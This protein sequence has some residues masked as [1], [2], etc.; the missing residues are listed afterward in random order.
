MGLERLLMV[1]EAKGCEFPAPP[2]CEVYL[3]PMGQAAVRRCFAI[4]T[5]LREGGV[6]VECDTVGRG[7]K[8][9]M[10]YADKLGARSVIVVGDNELETGAARL[11]DMA[12]GRGVQ[13]ILLDDS[14]YTT[15]YNKSPG[16]AA[17]RH[18]RAARAASWRTAL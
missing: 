1:M 6:S 5:R 9:Q 2:V 18:G 4:A 17:C 16:Q 12:T 14:L 8:A 10:K 15:L 13:D 7:L 3:A 11:K